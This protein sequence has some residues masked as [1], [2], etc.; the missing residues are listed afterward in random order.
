[1]LILIHASRN[2]WRIQQNPSVQRRKN[3]PRKFL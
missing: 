2:L 3:A 1:M